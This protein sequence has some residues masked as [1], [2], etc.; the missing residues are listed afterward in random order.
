MARDLGAGLA[1]TGSVVGADDGI[2]VTAELVDAE[3]GSVRARGSQEGSPGSVSAL[4]DGLVVQLLSLSEGEY[5]TS[6]ASVTSTSSEALKAYLLGKQAF[7]DGNYYDGVA[8]LDEALALDSTFAMAAIARAD[9]ATNAAGVS[10]GGYLD[11]AWRFRDRL[12]ARDLQYLEARRG[13]GG[14]R[15]DVEFIAQMERVTRD[16]PD[17]IEAWYWL[18]EGVF[19]QRGVVRDERWETRLRAL[20][21][22]IAAMDPDYYPVVDHLMFIEPTLGD[23][24]QRH[25]TYAK[26]V[27][28][29]FGDASVA[30]LVDVFSDLAR[31]GDRLV[32]DPGL[33]AST[34][35]NGLAYALWWPILALDLT[36]PD[37]IEFSEAYLEEARSR[38]GVDQS[39]SAV[40]NRTHAFNLALGRRAKADSVRAEAIEAGVVDRHERSVIYDAQWSGASLEDVEETVRRLD[41]GLSEVP[42]ERFGTA[43]AF[44]LVAVESWRFMRDST[45]TGW[46]AAERIMARVDQMPH[47]LNLQLEA[48]ALLLQAW[49]AARTDPSRAPEY[50]ERLFE[51]V[52]QGP[53]GVTGADVMLAVSTVHEELGDWAGALE[54][55]ERAGPRGSPAQPRLPIMLE[56]TARL[57]VS[58]GDTASAVT[59][60]RRYLTL[61]TYS[62]PSL[63]SE[64]DRARAALTELTA[65]PG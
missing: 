20:A 33:A 16:Q 25:A 15:T 28:R 5:T 50:L 65:G 9:G 51:I 59:N 29:P 7:W 6:I 39:L 8:H 2:V 30:G 49:S 17:R 4:A 21:D 43:E 64:V 19:H 60:Y 32:L 62:D 58:T 40:L 37:F 47:P 63:R 3:S 41:A 46:E 52:G 18:F 48:S 31:G 24:A 61:M 22:R 44:D 42:P 38:V 55:L 53:G 26:V 11:Q 1:L 12:S 36:P 54:S 10:S 27:E 56:R 23:S 35:A 13:L 14:D 45:Y 57:Q 34:D